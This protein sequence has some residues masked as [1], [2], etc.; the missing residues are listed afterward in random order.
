MNNLNEQQKVIVALNGD[1]EVFEELFIQYYPVAR[2]I[3]NNFFVSGMDKD[4]WDQESRIILYKAMQKFNPSMRVSFGSF[5][6]R[7]LRN[8][9]IDLVRLN[10]AQKRVPDNQVSSI[11]VN[12]NYYSDTV[13]DDASTCPERTTMYLERFE[14]VLGECSDM[15]REALM[16]MIS[17]PNKNLELN[18]NRALTNAFE[19]CR[20]KFK[21]D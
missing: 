18:E 1:D 10:N 11:D 21:N 6:S 16:N 7:S 8:R 14:W 17:E 3:Q 12:E 20:R 9:A 4:D 2:K 5:Y 15:E 19:R 13:M